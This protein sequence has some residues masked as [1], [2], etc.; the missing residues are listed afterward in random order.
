MK[1]CT[2][3]IALL[4]FGL[5]SVKLQAQEKAKW[6]EM[7]SF[8]VVMAKT[9]HP[10]EEGKMEPIR[11]R[12]G[13]MVTK[14]VAWQ[15]ST[16]PEGYDKDA[17]KESLKDLVEGAREIDKLVKEKA[18]DELIKTKLSALH[19]VFHQIMEKCQKEDHH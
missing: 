17:V 18:T 2:L 8:H 19:D 5:T 10:A 6:T 16:A 9:F 12:S 15:E 4:L 7:D 14:A 3:F 1:K 13:E 11:S